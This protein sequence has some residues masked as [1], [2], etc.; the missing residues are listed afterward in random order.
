MSV[1]LYVTELRENGR[2]VDSSTYDYMVL[3]TTAVAFD[4]G[5]DAA[6]EMSF[7][8]LWQNLDVTPSCKFYCACDWEETAD[9]A[10]LNHKKDREDLSLNSKHVEAGVR[11]V[12]AGVRIRVHDVAE[13]LCWEECGTGTVPQ[14]RIS[15]G[16]WQKV[17]QLCQ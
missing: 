7:L 1:T 13:D 15:A 11:D 4:A 16:I 5:E 12:L 6:T 3:H 9:S 8:G 10:L 14:K 17:S 2:K